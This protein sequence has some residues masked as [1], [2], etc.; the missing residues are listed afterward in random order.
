[1]ILILFKCLLVSIESLAITPYLIYYDLLL[2]I[3]NGSR[4]MVVEFFPLTD[5]ELEISPS[6]GK[7]SFDKSTLLEGI[8]SDDLCRY[9]PCEHNGTCFNTWNDFK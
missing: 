3:S 2:Q 5:D 6:F 1:M 7:V 9:N 8:V 4:K